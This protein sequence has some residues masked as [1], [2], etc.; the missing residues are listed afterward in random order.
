MSN[1]TN[2]VDTNKEGY[3]LASFY[4]GGVF[5]GAI[6]LGIVGTIV[7]FIIDSNSSGGGWN[8]RLAFLIL[9]IF[10]SWLGSI[11][12]P[13]IMGFVWGINRGLSKFSLSWRGLLIAGGIALVTNIVASVAL[14][15]SALNPALEILSVASF[16][17]YVLSFFIVRNLGRSISPDKYRPVE[18]NMYGNS[19]RYGAYLPQ[20]PY[21]NEYGNGYYPN[22]NS[23]SGQYPNQN[24]SYPATYPNN[25]YPYS[26]QSYDNPVNQNAPTPDGYPS[27][28]DSQYPAQPSQYS[29]PTENRDY[30]SSSPNDY[31]DSNSEAKIPYVHPPYESK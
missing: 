3:K 27:S 10:G 22:Q 14:Y 8:L 31:T 17:S 1:L 30:Y 16:G 23:Y 24:P 29:N 21:S 9:G 25:S 12:G 11:V 18:N 15:L 4:A 28:Y 20:G 2:G 26:Q 13:A 5:G 19:N 6:A 7:G